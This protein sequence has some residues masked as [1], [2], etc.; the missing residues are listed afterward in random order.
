MGKIDPELLY[1]FEAAFLGRKLIRFGYKDA[2]QR[3]T[4]REVEP[5]AMLIVPPLWY[6]VAWDP[7]RA[8]FRHFRMDRIS[9]PE[10]VNET[11]FRLRH[12]PFE[13]YACH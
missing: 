5:Q 13:D 3:E 4:Q 8:D 6:L 9:D 1:A 2:K 11:S 12:F 7:L 10:T